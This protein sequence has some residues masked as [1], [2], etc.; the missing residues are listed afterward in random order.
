ML[1]DVTISF[2]ERQIKCH[3]LILCGHSLWFKTACEGH[4]KEAKEPIIH[5]HEDDPD[6][7]EAMLRTCYGLDPFTNLEKPALHEKLQKFI[8][9]YVVADKYQVPGC[10][11]KAEAMISE[12]ATHRWAE[13]WDKNHLEDIVEQIYDATINSTDF[14][15]KW[16]VDRMH[17]ELRHFR[18][19][20]SKRLT[21]LLEAVP[22]L[23][24]AL[25]FAVHQYGENLQRNLRETIFPGPG[26]TTL[27]HNAA[28]DG[29]LEFCQAFVD[30]GVD[31]DLRDQN[32]ETPLHWAAW[33]GHP[34]VVRYLV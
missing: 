13:L 16:V 20:D 1:S 28:R 14:L 9:L 4:F 24:A 5:L 19:S 21:Q 8:A 6:A 25:V 30:I 32:G 11:S 26:R 27:F 12:A 18:E 33:S 7:L 23:A 29:S 2:S 3:R 15:R 34:A 17:L 31:V 22:E 10:Q